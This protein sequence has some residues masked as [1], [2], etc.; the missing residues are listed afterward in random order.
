[1]RL[2]YRNCRLI[3][4]PA[5]RPA[6]IAS[7]MGAID[8]RTFAIGLG[9]KTQVDTAALEALTNGTG[10]YLLLT[11]QLSTS[12]DDFF[13]VPRDEGRSAE[14]GHADRG[15]IGSLRADG[16]A[17]IRWRERV[18]TFRRRREDEAVRVRAR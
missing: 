9:S 5:N 12:T 18:G 3:A 7:V 6:S 16:L 15:P 8:S 1:M 2:G 4:C 11:G 10:G 13:A 14:S 17:W